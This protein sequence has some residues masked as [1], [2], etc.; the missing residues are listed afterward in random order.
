MTITLPDDPALLSDPEPP[1]YAQSF[2]KAIDE[3]RLAGFEVIQ[4]SETRLLLDLDHESNLKQC[5]MMLSRIGPLYDLKEQARWISKSRIGQHV[6]V[7]CK[8]LPFMTRVALQACLGS[9]P[10]REA[11]AVFLFQE[12]TEE[13]SVLFKPPQKLLNP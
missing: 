2:Q 7:S 9:D 3:A 4:S 13:P 8:P 11:L 1:D 5:A 10:V 12:G 6:V